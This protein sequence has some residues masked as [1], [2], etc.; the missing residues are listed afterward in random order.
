[1]TSVSQE[2]GHGWVGGGRRA[3]T[4]VPTAWAP[5]SP[6]TWLS[7]TPVLQPGLWDSLPGEG[8]VSGE[9]ALWTEQTRVL[10]RNSSF[11]KSPLW[12]TQ[13]LNLMFVKH[14]RTKIQILS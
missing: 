9:Q 14:P 2:K 12:G 10:K 13:T 4:E 1:M 6:G 3:T 8:L 11:Y 7:S 5:C